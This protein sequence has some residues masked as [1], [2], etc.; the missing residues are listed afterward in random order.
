M[1]SDEETTAKVVRYIL[2][3]PVRKGLVAS[4]HDYPYL[5]SDLGAVEGSF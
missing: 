5:G 4:P 2:E 3:S 1:L